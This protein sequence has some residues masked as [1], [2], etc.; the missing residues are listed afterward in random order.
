[1]KTGFNPNPGYT[2][3]K[4]RQ[5]APSTIP[6]GAVLD[7][8]AY[9]GKIVHV[10]GTATVTTILPPPS[11]ECV[12]VFDGAC[13]L[14]HNA[15]S[16]ILPNAANITTTA[17]STAVITE[18]GD[19]IARLVGGTLAGL[20]P[21]WN[22]LS[23]V[24]A[25]SSATVDIENT[26]DSTYDDYMIGYSNVVAST[27]N[28]TFRIRLKLSG[29][30]VTTST[31]GRMT[32]YGNSF[33]GTVN[34]DGASTGLSFIDTYTNNLGNDVSMPSTGTVWLSNPTLTTTRK[35]IRGEFTGYANTPA[36]VNSLFTGD[37]SGTGALTGVRFYFG[38][39]NILTGTFQL[40]G[41]RKS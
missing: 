28:Q 11:G 6:S 14:T 31:Y 13:T 1:M 26:Y 37:N 33:V 21:G 16:L 3:G 39:G 29:A 20:L 5:K 25:S 19:G 36:L 8:R 34:G 17:N 22:L 23:T 18:D 24:T 41:R 27:A 12:A 15:T 2:S 30:Y 32:F 40:Y 35:A 7:L 10:S 4:S 9:D 38:S